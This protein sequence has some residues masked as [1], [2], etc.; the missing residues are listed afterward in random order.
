MPIANDPIG[1]E[2][3][4]AEKAAAGAAAKDDGDHDEKGAID[5]HVWLD[6]RNA[7]A[8]T[9]AI[10]SDLAA[11]DPLHAAGYRD[12]A[13]AI[14]SSLDALDRE[15]EARIKTWRAHG[16]VSFHGS[17]TYFAKR[18]GLTIVAVIEPYPGSTPTGVYIQ[19]VLRVVR[20]RKVP[21]LFSEPQLDPKPAQIIADEAKIPLGVLDPVGGQPD[22]DSYEKMIRFDVAALEKAL[23]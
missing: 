15:T 18:Y 17:F 8:M 9:N 22:T 23:Q 5:P 4:H 16:F 1:D 13:T 3:A 19:E 14:V 2:E 10:A 20:A 7:I 12:R 6:P 11:V 21:A